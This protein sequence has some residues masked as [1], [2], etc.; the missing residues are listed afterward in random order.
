MDDDGVD[1]SR[2]DF[3]TTPSGPQGDPYD[4]QSGSSSTSTPAST[5]FAEAARSGTYDDAGY[6]SYDSPSDNDNDNSDSGSSSGATGSDT[7]GTSE[8]TP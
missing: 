5:S 8:P 3:S 7:P 1:Y 4:E 6:E 2:Q